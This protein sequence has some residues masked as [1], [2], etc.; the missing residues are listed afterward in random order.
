MYIYINVYIIIVYVY[1]CK[2]KTSKI[3]KNSKITKTSMKIQM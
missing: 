3:E 2:Q 1:V